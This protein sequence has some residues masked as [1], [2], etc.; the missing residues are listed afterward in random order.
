MNDPY[1]IL[2][3][4]MAR[5]GAEMDPAEAHG[6]LCGLL[7]VDVATPAA[8]CLEEVLA[9]VDPQDAGADVTRKLMEALV[10]QVRSS[11]ADE[12]F[13]FQPLLPEA[14]EPISERVRALGRWCEGFAVGIGLAGLGAKRVEALPESVS[15][16]IADMGEIARVELGDED[17]ESAEEAYAEL[18]EYVRVGVLLVS[19]E[20]RPPAT[21][22]P[23]VVH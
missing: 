20:L 7:A 9:G 15:E 17:G 22:I 10:T 4:Q 19:E 8:R 3:A 23:P 21:P 1:A 16:F 2:A 11:L 13:E 5:S 6:M 18:L 14:D 12:D